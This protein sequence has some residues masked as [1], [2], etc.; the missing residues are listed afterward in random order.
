MFHLQCDTHSISF[1]YNFVV[2]YFDVSEI[3]IC[4]V[5]NV[6]AS[7]HNPPYLFNNAKRKISENS[8]NVILVLFSFLQIMMEDRYILLR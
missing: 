6:V 3:D 7:I 4:F 1:S 5:T 2:Q 8:V